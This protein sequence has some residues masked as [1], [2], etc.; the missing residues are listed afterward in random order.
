MDEIQRR[1]REQFDRQ[2]ARYGRSHILADVADVE[3]ALSHVDLHPGMAALDVATGSGHTGLLCAGR[4]MKVILADIAPSMLERASRLAAEQ[5]LAVETREHTA[6]RLPY[7]DTTFDLVTCRVAAHH[8]SDPRAFVVEAARVLRP[9]G[10]LLLID[11]SVEDGEP[12]AEEWIHRVEKL[13]DPSHNRFLSPM[14]WK[15]LCASAAL[16][17]LHSVLEPF[18]QP[19]LEWYFETAATTSE[20]RAA[21]LEEIRTAP[22][23]ARRIY[24]IGEENGKI[25]WWWRRLTLVA[26]KGI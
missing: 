4:G 24:G 14:A 7:P 18:K 1:S 8:F 9:G 19:D 15:R 3:A 21:V 16:K 17:I 11:G 12:E 26:Q 13:R 6:E 10:S 22:E 23:S 25:V 2:S 20:N 5:G